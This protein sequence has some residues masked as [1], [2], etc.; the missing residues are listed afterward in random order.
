M[1]RHTTKQTTKSQQRLR[2]DASAALDKGRQ[3]LCDS[4]YDNTY[5]RHL[6]GSSVK[7]LNNIII[8]LT[9]CNAEV[10][11]E[12]RRI[13]TISKFLYRQSFSLRMCFIQPEVS[14]ATA[15]SSSSNWQSFNKARSL[16]V[17]APNNPSPGK[18]TVSREKCQVAG[19]LAPYVV[20]GSGASNDV[21]WTYFNASKSRFFYVASSPH[22]VKML[23]PSRETISIYQSFSVKNCAI[24]YVSTMGC[25]KITASPDEATE[26]DNPNKST[27]IFLYC[28]GTYKVLGT[29]HKSYA[30][31]SMFRDT[32]IRAHTSHMHSK[33]VASLVE[34]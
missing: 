8:P 23:F 7:M 24:V 1:F 3:I 28:D 30:V 29:P 6:P 31:C 4:I 26:D 33:L 14:S 13:Y 25:F 19:R 2:Y 16:E 15:V 32:V 10:S 21:S 22:T 9:G 17:S 11:A 5:A 34:A 18:I 27:C 12:S 20:D